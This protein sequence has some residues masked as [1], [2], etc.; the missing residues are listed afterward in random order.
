[1]RCATTAMKRRKQNFG[2]FE[3]KSSDGDGSAQYL[4][5]P[6]NDDNMRINMPDK[7]IHQDSSN[8]LDY[9][10][11]LYG[12]FSDVRDAAG[13][14]ALQVIEASKYEKIREVSYNIYLPLYT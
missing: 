12:L 3:F 14:S 13:R 8:Y 7:E 4:E 2:I 1:V 5:E 9:A 11:Q 6:L 10:N